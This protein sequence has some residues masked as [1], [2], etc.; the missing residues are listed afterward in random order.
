MTQKRIEIKEPKTLIMTNEF[1]NIS[2][3]EIEKIQE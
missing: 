3:D 2:K 1:E